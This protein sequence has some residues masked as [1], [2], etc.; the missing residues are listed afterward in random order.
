MHGHDER[1]H[2]DDLAFATRFLYDLV[3]R[4]AGG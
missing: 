3:V 4:F 2:L 1:I